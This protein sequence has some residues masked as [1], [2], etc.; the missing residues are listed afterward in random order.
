MKKVIFILFAVLIIIVG[1]KGRFT[2]G[3][4]V[5]MDIFT[6]TQGLTIEIL[7]IPEE[8]FEES[9]FRIDMRL[10]NEG[11]ADIEK[12]YLTLGLETDFITI[13]E[14]ALREPIT[15]SVSKEQVEFSLKGKSMLNPE[16]S[17]GLT[18]VSLSSKELEALREMH[19]STVLLTGCYAYKTKLS[20]GVCIDADLLGT[21]TVEKACVVEDKTL[22]S[23]GAPIAITKVEVDMLP[24][25]DLIKPQFLIHIQNKGKGEVVKTDNVKEACSGEQIDYDDFNV[26]KVNA[27]LFDKQL[28]CTP[29]LTEG[30]KTGLAKLKEKKDEIRCVLKEGM[31]K[32]MG[33]HTETL[34][35][36]LDYGY[37]QTLS[38][39]VDIKKLP[40]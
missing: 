16:G 25:E 23:Q 32:E 33:A 13:N 1:C 18:A 39:T 9:P 15:G 5:T 11:S 17:Q 36:E 20:E 8:I 30:G 26:I 28:T 22:K 27:Y 2:E 37:T 3:P 14:W 6:G 29:S 7:S 19:T 21:T 34:N 40:S 35:V 10:K 38:E 31:S 4:I 24:Q 12:G